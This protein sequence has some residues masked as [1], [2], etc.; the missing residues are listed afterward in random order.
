MSIK[1]T[2]SVITATFNAATH[3]PRLIASLRGQ[4]NKQFEWVVADGAS[5]DD[6][7]S[8]VNKIDDFKVI[9]SSEPDFGIY[10]AINR[11][12]KLATGNYYIVI[13]ADDFF[14]ENAIEN[15][16][17][18]LNKESIDVLVGQ[19]K[20]NGELI[21]IHHGKQFIY[22]ARALVASH[23]V[24]C[25]FKKSLHEEF[26]YYTN[27]YPILADT[28][29]IK[30]LFKD[31]RLNIKYSPKVF[32]NFSLGGISKSNGLRTQCEFGHIQLTTEKYKYFQAIIFFFR[33]IKEL[34]KRSS[35]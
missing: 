17:V 3:L 20:I 23:S 21:K 29:F 8:L 14:E 33:I 2:I 30:E 26:G 27:K 22:G 18:E 19:V 31:G 13:G 28:Y 6:T 4:T 9:I 11:A 10:D 7:I 16:Q 5:V 34:I 32:G 25:V 35:L 1:P 24:G 12:V 15:I